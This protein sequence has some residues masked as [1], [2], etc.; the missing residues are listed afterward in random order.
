M[1]RAKKTSAQSAPAPAFT[2]KAYPAHQAEVLIKG[3]GSAQLTG[4]CSG[5]LLLAEQ[6]PRD[7]PGKGFV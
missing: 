2:Q 6:V 7:A 5:A 4:P 3:T 1:S